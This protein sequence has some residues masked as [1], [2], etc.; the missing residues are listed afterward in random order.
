MEV[1]I[2]TEAHPWTCLWVFH[3]RG[4]VPSPSV[5]LGDIITWSGVLNKNN[6][7]RANHQHPLSVLLC[8]VCSMSGCHKLPSQSW[9]TVATNCEP[10]MTSSLTGFFQV[11]FFQV[12]K[13]YP[14]DSPKFSSWFSHLFLIY[15]RKFN[16]A[17]P[18]TNRHQYRSQLKWKLCF[19]QWPAT[20]NVP[21]PT[22]PASSH[23]MCLPL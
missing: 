5:T 11:F 1:R 15:L 7:R 16:H 10:N 4:I 2:T 14:I 13:V 23:Q 21:R 8:S 19:W 9:R 22:P 12:T 18:K 20:S 17:K 3:R 6:E